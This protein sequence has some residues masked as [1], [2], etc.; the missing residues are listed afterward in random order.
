MDRH[1]TW[2]VVAATL[3]T[4]LLPGAGSAF[5][6]EGQGPNPAPPQAVEARPPPSRLPVEPKYEVLRYLEDW[7]PVR[8]VPKCDRRDWSDRLKAMDL[9][10]DGCVWVNVGGQV[11]GRFESW[12][13]QAYGAIP[14][15]DDWGL[16][17]AR[18]H[19][20]LHLGR[21]LRL[22]AEGLWAGED[23]RDAGPR[24]TD[25]NHG[26]IL[27]LFAEGSTAP[28][29]SGLNAGAWVG[30]RELLFGKQRVIS[31]ADW[32]NVRRSFQGAGAWLKGD[33]WRLD[34][35]WTRPVLVDSDELDD[36]DEA[37]EFAG[38]EAHVNLSGG[39]VLEAYGL[40]LNRDTATWQGVTGPEERW[41]I[42]VGSWGP[43]GGTRFDY[44]TEVAWQFG[45]FA[46]NSISAGMATFE[47]G[48]K[49]CGPCFEPRIA[50]GADWAS[51]DEDGAGG[52][53]GTYNQ[54]FPTGHTWFGW[55]D[56]QARQNVVA[57]RLTATVKPTPRLFVR[58]DLHRFW[59]AEESDAVY[60]ASG[61]VL[62]A[63]GG[64][65]ESYVA[66]E[67]DLQAKYTIDR[68]WEVEAGY[69]HVWS[70]D[71]IQ[72]TGPSEDTDFWYVQVTFTF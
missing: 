53:L 37:T 31:P 19:V 12:A 29:G 1:G 60:A 49:P 62:R 27:N 59:R 55:A 6:G 11:R 47:V 57:A 7:A 10:S 52:D 68:H 64:G 33:G 5:A 2:A 36:W 3:L 30:R 65:A 44:D 40:Y 13:E 28:S 14:G 16:L 54:L 23:G 25:E 58:A 67:L 8:C 45:D 41:T 56:L 43:I 50:L 61:A 18:T 4:G 63:P 32:T 70:G 39:R 38:A 17:R 35:F 72:E 15:T 9:G 20:D 66:T 22:F 51:G 21:H 71:F 24:P 26:E 42:G 46:D 48:W 69:A 34:A